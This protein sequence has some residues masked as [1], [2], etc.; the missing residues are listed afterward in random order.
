MKTS[1][2]LILSVALLSPVGC[3]GGHASSP[4]RE[5]AQAAQP[6]RSRA[7]IGAQPGLFDFYVFNLSWTPEFCATHP[8][9]RVCA[10]RPGFIVH[11]LWPQNN[12]GTYPENC[13]NA[14]LP[15]NPSAYTTLIPTISL[16]EHEWVA[17]GTCSGLNPDEYF[18][19]V[20]TALRS[21][22]I[23]ATFAATSTPPS[24]VNPNVIL[25]QFRRDNPSFP[26]SSFVLSCRN[27]YLSGIDVCFD[28][29][30]SPTACQGMHSCR[31]R[32]I[33]IASR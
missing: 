14:A 4:S 32:T 5:T 33:K 28:K 12:D 1:L 2:A 7:N 15:T 22:E 16:I 31:A 21:F 18:A 25:D 6:S 10:A 27:N 29:D 23:P 26:R 30:L 20:R 8:D 24:S 9:S 17:H 11:G 19:Q 3:H 13:A